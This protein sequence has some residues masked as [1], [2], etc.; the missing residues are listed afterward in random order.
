MN[1][2]ILFTMGNE[3]DPW[4]SAK[5][6]KEKEQEE[7][8]STVRFEGSGKYEGVDIMTRIAEIQKELK[9][10]GEYVPELEGGLPFEDKMRIGKESAAELSRYKNPDEKAIAADMLKRTR[11]ILYD[12]RYDDTTKYLIKQAIAMK[13]VKDPKLRWAI[14]DAVHSLSLDGL[15]NPDNS[16]Y[17]TKN[18]LDVNKFD[19]SIRPNDLGIALDPQREA[20]MGDIDAHL[21]DILGR[22]D[23]M[24]VERYN[25]GIKAR[26][27]SAEFGDRFKVYRDDIL[28]YMRETKDVIASM[29]KSIS[30]L[31]GVCENNEAAYKVMEMSDLI[32]YRRG[33]VDAAAYFNMI[34]DNQRD[35]WQSG[36]DE[37]LDN[38]LLRLQAAQDHCRCVR[39]RPIKEWKYIK[40]PRMLPRETLE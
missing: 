31:L 39:L 21:R 11:S 40:P 16:M 5:R 12:R 30:D 18:R 19:F 27:V 17:G 24:L 36:M 22:V 23:P 10:R 4:E 29:D 6:R 2:I 8:E 32:G 37:R 1:N 26:K 28:R 35:S 20:I 7:E 25:S 14:N 9:D 13:E 38:V 34:S 3:I 33:I 15:K